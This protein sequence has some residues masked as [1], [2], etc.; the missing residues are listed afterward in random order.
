MTSKCFIFL[1]KSGILQIYYEGIH[2]FFFLGGVGLCSLRKYEYPKRAPPSFYQV[3]NN[4]KERPDVWI[5]SPEKLVLY[6]FCI[7]PS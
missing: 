5:E 6:S 1:G 7:I 4:S 3:T 2:T